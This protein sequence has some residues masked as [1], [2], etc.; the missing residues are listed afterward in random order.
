MVESLIM[1]VLF[2]LCTVEL[3]SPSSPI[4]WN[5][6]RRQNKVWRRQSRC[7]CHYWTHTK[8]DLTEGCKGASANS[9]LSPYNCPSVSTS[10]STYDCTP[11]TSYVL[12]TTQRKEYVWLA[13]GQNNTTRAAFMEDWITISH[14][15]LVTSRMQL[16][17]IGPPI[18]FRI[19]N[20]R[21]ALWCFSQRRSTGR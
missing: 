17:H 18:Y 11:S 15:L 8:C 19:S 3:N 4:Q 13:N 14:T 9:P 7:G 2:V 16:I 5:P 1:G 21:R 20:G 10:K 6:P 12:S